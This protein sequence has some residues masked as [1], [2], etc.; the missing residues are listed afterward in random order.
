VQ[1]TMEG[2]YSAGA[3]DEVRAAKLRIVRLDPEIAAAFP[4]S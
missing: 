3:I 4:T 1:E 2:M